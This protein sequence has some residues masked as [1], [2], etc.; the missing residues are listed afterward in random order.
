MGAKKS[1]KVK[2]PRRQW[3]RS[4]VQRPHSTKRGQRGYDRKRP[5]PD[6]EQDI[7]DGSGTD[8]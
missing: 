2:R 6:P 5:P 4:P 1:G 7:E 8:P 3:T